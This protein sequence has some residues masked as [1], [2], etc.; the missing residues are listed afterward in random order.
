M[1]A[2]LALIVEDEY[3]IASDVANGL[4][5][6]GFD[7]ACV[8]S[9]RAAETWL[10]DHRPDLAIIDIQL[11]DGQRGIAANRLKALNVPFIVHSGYDPEFQAPA[12]HDAP[13]LPKP[14]SIQ[15]LVT[16]AIQMIEGQP[17]T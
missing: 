6:G 8:A 2:P 10:A 3:L 16:L 1:S 9:E 12:F 5:D 13:Y 11:L 17:R 15:D 4:M 7:V 14:T